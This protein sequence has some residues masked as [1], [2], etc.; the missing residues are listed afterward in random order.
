MLCLIQYWLEQL[1]WI[2]LLM[3]LTV[4]EPFRLHHVLQDDFVHS[5][6]A[7]FVLLVPEN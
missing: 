6:I 5:T 7:A 2:H 3:Q 1:V 4:V